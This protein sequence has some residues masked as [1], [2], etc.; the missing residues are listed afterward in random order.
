MIS[1]T[2]IGNVGSVDAVKAVNDTQVFGFTVA[3]NKTWKNANGEKQEKTVWFKVSLWGNR[4]NVSPYI[5]KGDTIGITADWLD[6][7]AYTNKAGEPT[8]SIEI[9]NPEIQLIGK[10]VKNDNSHSAAPAAS[11]GA[12]LEDMPF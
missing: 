12:D 3:A 2:I 7:N 1:V 10:T 8:A 5:H 11:N 6:L 9:K 4:T